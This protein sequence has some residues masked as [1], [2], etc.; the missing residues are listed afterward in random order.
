M[1]KR[2]TQDQIQQ[3][4][5]LYSEL[6]T[7]SAVA[8]QMGISSSTVSRYIKEASATKTYNESVAPKPIEEIPSLFITSYSE[9]TPEEQ[10]SYNEWLGEFGR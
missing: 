9:L 7:Y 8:K 1:A 6:G 10:A 3:M 4:L 2:I 5:T